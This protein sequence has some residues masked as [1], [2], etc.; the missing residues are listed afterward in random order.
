MR[1]EKLVAE[2]LGLQGLR[3]RGVRVDAAARTVV[4]RVGQRARRHRCPK[5]RHRTAA[6]YDGHERRWRHIPLGRYRVW[7][8]ARVAR[9]ECPSHGVVVEAV[10]WAD[11]D[12]AFTKAFDDLAA[13]LAR[14]MSKTAVTR[15]LKV[16]WS[17]VGGMIERAVR[18]HRV[19]DPLE[20]L[21]FMGIDEKAYRRGHKYLTIV[22]KHGAPGPVWI[23]E[24]RNAET[25]AAFFEELG[26]DR[27]WLVARVSMD[28]S[29]SYIAAIRKHA[30]QARIAFDPFHVVRLGN[31]ALQ[32]VRRDQARIHKGSPSGDVL[33]GE[34]WLLLRAR[35]AL[36][37]GQKLR[38]S[39]VA[40][41][42]KVVYR[43]VLLKEELRALY[44]CHPDAAPGHL[45]EWCSWASR[46]RIRA[47]VRLARTLRKHKEGVLNAVRYGLTNAKLESLNAK[48]DLVQR[49][50]FGFHS[51]QALIALIWLCCS[52]IP[53][54]LPTD[55]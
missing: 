8:Q 10:P 47:F 21:M 13:W 20:G 3:V 36:D 19:G 18:R 23:G 7:L 27:S 48:I 53:I 28:M 38:L 44:R 35:E 34:R 51:A 24:G 40:R 4:V 6:A 11:H 32:S 46:S 54:P 30:P 14:E 9:I 33:K 42:N 16:S 31:E 43:G 50:A 41:L 37:E 45:R 5:C 49:R 25:L 39:N 52:Q 22:V 29:A 15:F 1:P 12:T 2:L 26:P 17:A 55:G